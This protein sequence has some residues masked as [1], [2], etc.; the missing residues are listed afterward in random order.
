MLFPNTLPFDPAAPAEALAQLPAAPAVFA[1]RGQTGEPYL[2]HTADLRRRVTR[3]LTPAPAQSKRLALAGLVRHIEWAPTAS[4][5]SAQLLLY[6]ASI[7]AF[8]DRATQRLHLR[9]A[10]FLRM[11][12]RNRFPRAWVTTSLSLSAAADLFGPF[13]S[14]NAAERYAEAALD[15]HLLRRCFQ[16]LDPDPEFPG[17]I[18]SEMKKCL[19]PCYGGCSDERYS[20]EASA[21]HA[22]FRTRGA[23]L[24]ATLSQ[25]RNAA[26]EA[27]DFEAAAALHTRHSKAEAVAALAP[28][29]SGALAA[30]HGVLV[31]PAVTPDTVDLYLLQNGTFT[32]PAPFSVL[33]MRLP[34]EQS[35]SSSLFAHPAA[36][37]AVP[38]REPPPPE[39]QQQREM[40]G[41]QSRVP[42]VSHLRP[43]QENPSDPP[44]PQTLSAG[45]DTTTTP[46]D[47]LQTAIT[48]LTASLQPPTRQQ[49]CDHQSLL[50]RWYFR[51][52]GKREGELILTGPDSNPARKQDPLKPLLRACARVYRAH[53]EKTAPSTNS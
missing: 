17:C 46:D 14:R 28:E 36:M 52:Q 1:L 22:F 31:Q 10:S 2:N 39:P 35:G 53:V 34:N 26:S 49:L 12:M 18:Y 7:E 9:P 51:P 50:A 43:G 40:L 32:G 38:L 33:G 21:V 27:L 29:L 6:R 3:L 47:R 19:A 44:R 8:G 13:P 4:G 24:L 23:S 48:S 16:D 42:Q 37:A 30:Q 45:S 15:L 5:F 20:E 41:E 25:A 11:G